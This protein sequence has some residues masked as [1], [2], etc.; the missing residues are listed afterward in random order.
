MENT[1]TFVRPNN[2][3]AIYEVGPM[4]AA[5]VQR[6]T[7]CRD[8]ETKGVVPSEDVGVPS[9]GRYAE[10]ERSVHNSPGLRRHV[11]SRLTLVVRPV[12]ITTI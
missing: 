3:E 10:E 9:S 4:P 12:P 5:P 7:L 2:R 11:I 6:P 8:T 1:V